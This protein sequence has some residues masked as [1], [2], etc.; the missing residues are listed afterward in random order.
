MVSGVAMS[1]KR[2]SDVPLHKL[3]DKNSMRAQEDD[4]S[5]RFGPPVEAGYGIK[6][7]DADTLVRGC[8]PLAELL[9]ACC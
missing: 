9:L 7:A 4:D 8:W 5:D 1:K 2:Q 3:D 6:M